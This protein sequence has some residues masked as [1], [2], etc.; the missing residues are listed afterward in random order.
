MLT[1][2]VHI[3]LSWKIKESLTGK[4]AH[5]FH[6]RFTTHIPI[7]HSLDSQHNTY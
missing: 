4:F 5:H 3:T 7:L 2:Q 1:F 6:F